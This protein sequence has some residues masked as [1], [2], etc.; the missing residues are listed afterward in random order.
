MS[1]CIEVKREPEKPSARIELPEEVA[2]PKIGSEVSVTVKGILKHVEVGEPYSD[3]DEYHTAKG[4][5]KIEISSVKIE[6]K[7]VFADL[8]EDE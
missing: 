6:G 3:Y 8:A 2:I 5:L 7:N 4:Q 1:Q